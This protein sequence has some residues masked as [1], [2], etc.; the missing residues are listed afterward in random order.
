MIIIVAENL[1]RRR[2]GSSRKFFERVGQIRAKKVQVSQL[3]V[4]QL[5]VPLEEVC[6]PLDDGQHPHH[7]E[8][9]IGE[10]VADLGHAGSLHGVGVE[11]RHVWPR[12]ACAGP[13]QLVHDGPN[14]GH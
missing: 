4:A 14:V 13:V 11:A 3:L 1:L 10:I 7:I 5:G 8:V 2:V 12:E 9:H 6:H